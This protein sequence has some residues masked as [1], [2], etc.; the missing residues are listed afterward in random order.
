MS[1][2]LQ[3]VTTDFYHLQDTLLSY[4]YIAA[5]MPSIVQ[6]NDQWFHRRL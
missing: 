5:Y 3:K 1:Y 4:L 2:L 6:T